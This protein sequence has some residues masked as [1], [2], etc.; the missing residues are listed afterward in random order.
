V[1]AKR[2]PGV[3]VSGPWERG[4]ARPGEKTK[5]NI[6]VALLIRKYLFASLSLYHHHLL[7]LK[8]IKKKKSKGKINRGLYFPVLS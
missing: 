3:N 2:Y 7:R 1:V 4:P 5:W 8:N 6:V